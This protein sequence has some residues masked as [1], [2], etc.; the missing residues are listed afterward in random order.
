[1][2]PATWTAAVFPA[3][4][5]AV[6]TGHAI[7][8]RRRWSD[9]GIRVVVPWPVALPVQGLA[10]AAVS[11][12]LVP[13]IGAAA[14]TGLAAA[15]WIGLLAVNS[16]LACQKIPY[17]APHRAALVGILASLPGLTVPRV[18]TVGVTVLLCVGA[19]LAARALTRRGLGL[20]D[21]RLMWAWTATLSWWTGPT[22]LAYGLIAAC[23]LQI[24]VHLSVWA[25][26]RIRRTSTGPVHLPFAPAL[27]VGFLAAAGAVIA[28]ASAAAA[29]CTSATLGC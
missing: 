14:A 11:T 6:L 8:H 2:I 29:G 5:L 17:E 1:M 18:V 12:A 7:T 4:A 23:L 26:R 10:A 15:I 21:V 13:R 27:T 20:S 24:P 9:R 19:P 25:T 22:V 3:G 16:D 28:S